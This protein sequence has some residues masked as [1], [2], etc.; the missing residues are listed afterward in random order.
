MKGM[1]T[2]LKCEIM[3]MLNVLIMVFKFILV[4]V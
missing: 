2:C 1:F 3:L 4:S